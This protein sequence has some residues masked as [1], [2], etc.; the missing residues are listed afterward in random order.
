MRIK[1]GEKGVQ[2]ECKG[3]FFRYTENGFTGKNNRVVLTREL[4]PLKS[5]SCSGCPECAGLDAELAARVNEINFLQF[6][7]TLKSGDTVKL[8]QVPVDRDW[9]TGELKKWYYEVSRANT[10]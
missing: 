3:R 5:I 10:T 7:P 1:I 4:R 8:V 6:N 9:G 2:E